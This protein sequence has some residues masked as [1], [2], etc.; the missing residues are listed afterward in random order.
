MKKIT[1]L[2]ILVFLTF[3]ISWQNN[4]IAAT[5]TT[6]PLTTATQP[7]GATITQTQQAATTSQ[8][9]I[10]S[11]NTL[12][13]LSATPTN[14]DVA[15]LLQN[16][17][18]NNSA[19]RANFNL[20]YGTN[21]PLTG[22]VSDAD[23]A[24]ILGIVGTTNYDQA[25]FLT[26]VQKAGDLYRALKFNDV[27]KPNFNTLYGTTL[28]ESGSLGSSDRAVLFGVV[29]D[30]SYSQTNFLTEVVQAGSFYN[31][32]K[33]NTSN[34]DS[35]N[36]LYET[37]ISSTSALTDADRVEIF[38]LVSDP[39]YN[40]ADLLSSV[41]DFGNLYTVLKTNTSYQGWLN[42]LYDG[43]LKSTGPLNILDKT[44]LF[45]VVDVTGYN[46]TKYLDNLTKTASLLGGL[47]GGASSYLGWWN[48]LYDGHLPVTGHP[49]PE[50]RETLFAIT[51]AA[52]YDQNKYSDNIK[53]AASLLG[54]LQAGA[55]NYLG[56]WNWLYDGHL[57]A[58]GHPTDTDR[59]LLLWVTS[60][61]SYDQNL[62]SE[63]IKR[64][65]S[66]LGALQ[67]NSI[68]RAQ[69]NAM[70]A[71]TLQSS[72]HP[73]PKD[74]EALLA[75]TKTSGYVQ[76]NFL[77]SLSSGTPL[78]I[79][80]GPTPTPLP[81][82]TPIPNPNGLFNLNTFWNTPLAA[83][84]AIHWNSSN[85]VNELVAETRMAGPWINTTTYSTPVFYVNS[86]TPRVPIAIVQNGQALTFTKLWEESQKGVPVPSN[87]FA[88]S[89]TDG[90]VT[91]I[92]PDT[93]ELWEYW[94]FRKVNGQYQAS[95]GGKIDNIYTSD[96]TMPI[97]KN[98]AGADE[99][100]GA[101]ATS[102]PIAGGLIT[103]KDLQAGKISHELAVAII[104][105]KNTFVWPAKRSDGYTTGPNNIPEGTRFRF[106]ANVYINPSWPPILKMIVAAIR[107]YGMVVRDK[108]GA[109]VLFGEDP[110]QYGPG[111]PYAAYYGG[112]QLWEIMGQMMP[113]N[114]LQAL[115]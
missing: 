112:K 98:S 26:T 3:F 10:D 53:K 45:S 11:K 61:S 35:F 94:Q 59:E 17:L 68:Y 44:I 74:R 22:S 21:I 40:Q 75:I 85:L 82:P 77:Y 103:L 48:W 80:P 93:G 70:Y 111:D 108:A 106:P 19:N 110:T 39:N 72:G 88:S 107:D 8:N 2:I 63:Y 38:S 56:W 29:N 14:E 16:A 81:S 50:D 79:N 67:A 47:Q 97:V 101:T 104:Q 15:N 58:T 83:N 34:R 65:A 36:L 5:T 30:P 6:T 114:Q 105:P 73:S 64:S 76:Q 32:L 113:W 90:H 28:T 69:F 91:I 18:L 24:T 27:Y 20:L 42:W 87:V 57:L 51:R 109:V 23:H 7:T 62:Y 99:Y 60:A 89:G 100:W 115:A 66:L 1:A 92:N 84:Q 12:L 4:L 46:Q 9:L 86:Q 55:A 25:T 71:A 13:T 31:N 95:W 102:L 78:P 33:N 96:G 54:A 43:T 49:N 37:S 52:G 41:Q